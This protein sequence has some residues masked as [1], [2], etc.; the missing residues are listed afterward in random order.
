[1]KK[2]VAIVAALSLVLVMGLA[3]CG[4]S[5]PTPSETVDKFLAAVKAE[6]AET[7]KTVYEPG[8]FV[9]TNAIDSEEIDESVL[10]EEEEMFKALKAKLL[11]FDYEVVGEEI[12]EDKATVQV[13]ITT[14]PFGSA[15]TEF[16]SEYMTQALALAFS[17]ASE[18]KMEKLA[19]T[20]FV[21]K[22]NGLSEKSYTGT[23]SLTLNK[24][25][26]G[27]KVAEIPEDS[28]FYN[29]LFGN[30]IES[31]KNLEEAYSDLGE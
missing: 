19:E 25:D 5:G 1:M 3:G 27:W 7:I 11:E 4:D 15:V 20:L 14:Y 8:E 24:T 31:M 23:T 29:V 16:I 28:D 21:E 12:N 13:K 6:D 26:E 17:D 10:D 18:E 9:L 30:M 2:T 22:I